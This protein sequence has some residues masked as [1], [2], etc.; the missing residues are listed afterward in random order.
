MSKFFENRKHVEIS[1]FDE[2]LPVE[3]NKFYEN[4]SLAEI[5]NSNPVPCYEYNYH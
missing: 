1:K 5:S 3:I 4:K 2:N